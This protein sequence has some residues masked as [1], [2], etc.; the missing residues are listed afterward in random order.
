MTGVRR[1]IGHELG[2]GAF[3][4]FDL[5]PAVPA[6]CRQ[7]REGLQRPTR[8]EDEDLGN[9]CPSVGTTV[10]TLP[11]ALVLRRVAFRKHCSCLLVLGGNCLLSIRPDARD[12]DLA[13]RLRLNHRVGL[14]D[15][16][17]G[18]HVTQRTLRRCRQGQPRASDD[19]APPTCHHDDAASSRSTAPDPASTT[20]DGAG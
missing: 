10:R 9:H 2:T 11:E 13:Y 16:Y 14:P 18:H 8:D 19:S 17:L 6:L 20:L 5:R 4:M 12:R 1:R 3:G 7:H 15:G